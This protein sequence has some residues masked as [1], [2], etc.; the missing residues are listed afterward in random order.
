MMCNIVR[1]RLAAVAAMVFTPS[2]F[3]QP[4][5]VFVSSAYWDTNLSFNRCMERTERVL[6]E[7]NFTGVNRVD[8]VVG[9]GYGDYSTQV[10]C[11]TAKGI[12]IVFVTG[13]DSK[14]VGQHVLAIRDK[15]QAAE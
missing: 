11:A 8:A 15:L 12:I 13:P 4:A 7:L 6:G 9:G 2:A 5:S 3:A 14:A 10:I 1:L